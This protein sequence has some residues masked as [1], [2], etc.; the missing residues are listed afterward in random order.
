MPQAAM[1]T[2]KENDERMLAAFTLIM[3]TRRRRGF[4]RRN[5]LVCRVYWRVYQ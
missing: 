4:Q 5:C 2:R 3:M 1:N